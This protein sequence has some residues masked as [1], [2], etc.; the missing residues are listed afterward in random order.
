[1]SGTLYTIGYSGFHTGDFID[2]LASK[3]VNVLID[4]RSKPYSS[5]YPEFNKEH[6]AKKL[7]QEDIHYR[8]YSNEF[9]ARQTNRTFFSVEG[10]LD[11]D[12]F[13][14][15]DIFKHGFARVKEGI[16]QNYSLVFMCAESNPI[17]CHRTIMVARAFFDVGYEI[18]HLMKDGKAISHKDVEQKILDMFYPDR[19]QMTF[20][21]EEKDDADL[22]GKAYRKLNADIGF[23]M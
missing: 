20:F 22:I 19:A 8:N 18:T 4:V 6:F 1:M 15:S 16:E 9:G 11:F 14:K 13:S 12:K 5:Y 23:R 3:G 7:A 21:S 10:F 2:L 17:D